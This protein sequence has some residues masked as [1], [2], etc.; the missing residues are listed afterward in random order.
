M[1]SRNCRHSFL[2]ALAASVLVMSA[3][4]ASAQRARKAPPPPPPQPAYAPVAAYPPVYNWTGLY[5]GGSV[6]YALANVDHYYDRQNGKNDHG[7]VWSDASGF[8]I[9]GHVGYN[10]MLPNLVVIGVEAEIGYLGINDEKIVIKDD[11]VLRIDTG[12]FGTLRARLGY[13][14]GTFMPYVTAGFAFVDIENAG[15]NPANAARFLTNNEVRP[16]FVVGAGAEYAFSPG[17]VGRIEYLYID[18]KE[19]EVRNLENEMMRF[20][21]NF[22]LIRAGLSFRY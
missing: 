10:V 1:S 19:Y 21:N 5:F 7:Q 9:S 18:T 11:D 15:G 6:G 3:S 16:G 2:A 13:A 17:M 4:D 22:H 14:F 12:M 20:D 8:A